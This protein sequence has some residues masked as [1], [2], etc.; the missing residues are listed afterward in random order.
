MKKNR[1]VLIAKA[2]LN[3]QNREYE[4]K[5]NKQQIEELN[6]GL[7]DLTQAIEMLKTA[8]S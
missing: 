4:R 8:N 3:Q 2:K 1:D 5:L 7:V 6:K